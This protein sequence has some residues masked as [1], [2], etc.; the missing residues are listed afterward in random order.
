MLYKIINKP[1]AKIKRVNIDDKETAKS[2]Y[3]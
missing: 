1:K 2:P 3:I